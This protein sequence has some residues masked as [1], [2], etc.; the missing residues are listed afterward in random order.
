ML[1][2]IPASFEDVLMEPLGAV[3]LVP[4]LGD[5]SCSNGV[6]TGLVNGGEVESCRVMSSA[7]SFSA[8]LVSFPTVSLL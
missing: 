6:A 8:D 3:P 4:S 7:S 5:E 2:P 1:T